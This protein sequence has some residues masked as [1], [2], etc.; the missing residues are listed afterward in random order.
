M[1][2]DAKIAF[3]EIA[4]QNEEATSFLHVF[5]EWVQTQ[6]DLM[7]RDKPVPPREFVI[8]NMRLIFTLT[9]NEFFLAHKDKLLP[10]ILASSVAYVD[11]ERFRTHESVLD[12]V[13]SQVLKSQYADVFYMVAFIVGGIQHMIAM[14]E[15][16]REFSYDPCPPPSAPVPEPEAVRAAVTAPA[17]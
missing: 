9:C 2:F 10:V 7:D 5:Y 3:R 6:D 12:R 16:Y 11:S 8:T 15:K 13:A 1:P 17:A 14:A 4:A